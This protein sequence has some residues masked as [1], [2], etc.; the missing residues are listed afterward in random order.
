M[1]GK[2][3]EKNPTKTT[4]KEKN[5]TH[6]HVHKHTHL[7]MFDEQSWSPSACSLLP[8]PTGASRSNEALPFCTHPDINVLAG[9]FYLRGFLEDEVR[10]ISV[11]KPQIHT[12]LSDTHTRHT[13]TSLHSSCACLSDGKQRRT[14]APL[15][16]G[17]SCLWCWQ[18]KQSSRLT[19]C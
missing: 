4:G 2:K 3:E 18:P 11:A 17:I 5:Y 1:H 10:A 13:T 12:Y 7:Q 19:S 14:P 16:L 8:S 15:I 9:F 6:A